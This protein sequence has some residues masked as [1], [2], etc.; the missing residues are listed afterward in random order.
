[1]TVTTIGYGDLVPQNIV[2]TWTASIIMFVGSCIYAYVVGTI[3][4]SLSEANP[5]EKDFQRTLDNLDDYMNMACC[6]LEHKTRLRSFFNKRALIDK[7]KYYK[8]VLNECSPEIQAD[9]AARLYKDSLL[10]VKFMRPPDEIDDHRRFHFI[11][12]VSMKMQVAAFPAHEFLITKGESTGNTSRMFIIRRGLV[13]SSGR[14][15]SREAGKNVLGED[16]I[17]RSQTRMYSAKSLTFVEAVALQSQDLHAILESSTT[18]WAQKRQI[19]RH[20]MWV[21]FR[22]VMLEVMRRIKSVRMIAS[23]A[24][25]D[26]DLE[27]CPDMLFAAP[28][29]PFDPTK[30]IRRMRRAQ[31]LAAYNATRQDHGELES[32]EGTP[33]T[34]RSE[35]GPWSKYLDSPSASPRARSRSN[36]FCAEHARNMFGKSESPE[37]PRKDHNGLSME[38]RSLCTKIATL[39]I[40]RTSP[41]DAWLFLS[42]MK[43]EWRK[44]RERSLSPETVFD[45]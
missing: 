29:Q 17:C 7:D 37:P 1:M 33:R 6:S 44:I 45:L 19:R 26:I 40:A 24:D 20:S 41:R 4:G 25:L 21:G 38:E 23:V 35:Q 22:N 39:N 5:A 42:A 10:H 31:A 36:S 16:I 34:P 15:F 13:G 11:G 28:G 27:V 43:E 9:L 8:A 18:Y 30:A 2:E 12:A 3:V 32:L 14:I